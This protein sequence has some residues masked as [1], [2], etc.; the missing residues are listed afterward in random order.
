MNEEK[1]IQE[2][3]GSRNPFVVPE[4]Y[5]ET[6]ADQLMASLPERQPEL[7]PRAKRVWLRP[8]R[9]AA[10]VVCVFALGALSW[11]VLSPESHQPIQA[12]AVQ[13]SNDAE[14]EA[15]ADYVMLDNYDI[16]ACLSDE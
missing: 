13:L 5:F 2:K 12:K 8:L 10:A 1:Y 16:Y 6:F 14:F 4:G 3:V 9:Y 11:L 7:Q 15:A